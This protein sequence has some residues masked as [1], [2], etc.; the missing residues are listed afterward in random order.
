[1]ERV[2]SS[3]FLPDWLEKLQASFKDLD[4]RFEGGES[5]REAMNRIVQVAD[6]IW[7]GEAKHTIMATYGNL[8]ALLLKHYHEDTGFEEWC[9]LTNPDVFLLTWLDHEVK[10]QR[11]WK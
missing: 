6:E 7:K 2:L 11:I 5:G 4:L 3:R 1:M 10:W 9:K 8:M